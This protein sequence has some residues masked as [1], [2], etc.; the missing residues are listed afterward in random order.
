MCTTTRP[1]TA[2][3]FNNGL[4]IKFTTQTP[5][6]ADAQWRDGSARQLRLLLGQNIPNPVSQ[7]TTIHFQLNQTQPVTLRVYDVDGHLVR[8]LLAGPVQAGRHAVDWSGDNNQGLA[9]PSGVY[10]YSI[11]SNNFIETRRMTLMK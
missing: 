10:F 9:V 7:G 3:N 8:T 11:Q 6:A 4:A 1:A 2:A 5:G